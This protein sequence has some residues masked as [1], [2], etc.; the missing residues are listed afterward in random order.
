MYD[1]EEYRDSIRGFYLDIKELPKDAGIYTIKAIL[2]N[3]KN[4]TEAEDIVKVEITKAIY[5]VDNI[6]FEDKEV[7]YNGSEN[8]LEIQGE[9]PDWITIEYE[10]NTAIEAG[11]Y[12][13]KVNFIVKNENYGPIESK[14]AV[15][16]I[17][18]A[19][20]SIKIKNAEELSKIYNGEEMKI[21]WEV[22]L[23]LPLRRNLCWLMEKISQ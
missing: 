19:E 23:V 14:T 21:K 7:I 22:V 1:L 4:Y 9:L 20:G 11:I 18:Q 15:L 16:T 8:R 13:A 10:N 6:K 3:G 12:N 17:E 5:N 2:E